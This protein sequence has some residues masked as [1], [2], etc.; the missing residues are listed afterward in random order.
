MKVLIFTSTFPRFAGDPTSI[1]VLEYAKQLLKT[2]N[3]VE[4]LAPHAPNIKKEES[5]DG[6]KIKRIQYVY[7]AKYQSLAYGAGIPANMNKS[8]W[9]KIQFLPYIFASLGE[10]S[11]EVEEFD[12]NVVH[13]MWAFPQGFI[14]SLLK[15]FKKFP[16]VISIFGAEVYLAKRYHISRLIKFA[17]NNADALGANSI[18]TINA[19]HAC[20][21]EKDIELIFVG[22]DTKRFKP[23]N[24]ASIVRRKYDL[25]GSSLILTIGRMVERKGHEYLIRA[26]PYILEEFPNAKLMLVSGGPLEKRLRDVAQKLELRRSVIFTG[27]VSH[28]ELPG[29]YA[30]CDV[31]CLPA[32][33]DFKGD[34]EG[35]QGLVTKEAMATR[36]PVVATDVG[37]IPDIVKN[38]DTGLL[39]RQKDSKELAHAIIRLL[40]DSEL[41]ERIARKGY[42][43]VKREFSYEA[44]SKKYLKIYEDIAK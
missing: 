16:L 4:V 10:L 3:D 26:M 39:V 20:G 11:K 29:C 40:R 13:A 31:F 25:G 32:I 34:T 35:G 24:N 44:M 14:A 23:N 6:V 37:G 38:E 5:I 1:F 9:A 36:K 21:V 43:V 7:P 28:E 15:K 27:K 33:V 41:R 42:E 12:P 22:V 8:Y 30:A 18:A 2:G 19:A 17:A